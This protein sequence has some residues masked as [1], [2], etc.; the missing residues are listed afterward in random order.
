M[1]LESL[2]EKLTRLE[3]LGGPSELAAI[4]A[5]LVERIRQV[6]GEGWTPGH[7]DVERKSGQ[8][9]AAGACY[10]L[11]VSQKA[12]IHANT[13]SL[14]VKPSPR[15]PHWPFGPLAWKPASLNRMAV[16]GAALMLAELARQ[17]RAGIQ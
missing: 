17:M 12:L 15:Q 7:D 13:G 6:E 1:N 8:L 9:A 11:A 3:A 16:K 10:A 2:Q 5:L 4:E 14:D